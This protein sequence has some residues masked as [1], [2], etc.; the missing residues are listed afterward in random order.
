MDT[1]LEVHDTPSVTIQVNSFE[2]GKNEKPLDW[3]MEK[4]REGGGDQPEIFTRYVG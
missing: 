4:F 1:W 2:P 3:A